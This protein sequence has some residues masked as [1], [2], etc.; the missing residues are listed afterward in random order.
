MYVWMHIAI[1]I[2]TFDD[3]ICLNVHFGVTRELGNR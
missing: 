2:I 3:V 1:R